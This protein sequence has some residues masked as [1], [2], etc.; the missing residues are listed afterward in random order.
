M[1]FNN[2]IWPSS[3]ET[4]RSLDVT[5]KKDV[6]TLQGWQRF[7]PVGWIPADGSLS[8]L[9]SPSGHTP[10]ND[11]RYL[12]DGTAINKA[13]VV[14]NIWRTVWMAFYG[15]QLSFPLHAGPRFGTF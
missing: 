8:M 2:Q 12:P 9:G 7:A 11:V 1:S 3:S 13:V 10:G 5:L 6:R 14:A 4:Q 15:F